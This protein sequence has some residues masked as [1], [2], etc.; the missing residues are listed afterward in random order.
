MREGQIVAEEQRHDLRWPRRTTS[1][2]FPSTIEITGRLEY[3]W[4]RVHYYSPRT[5]IDK[6]NH[7]CAKWQPV[8]LSE[9]AA[10][11]EHFMD[12]CRLLGQPAD[13][14][15]TAAFKARKQGRSSRSQMP[16]HEAAT[17]VKLIQDRCPN[18]LKLGFALW[19]RRPIQELVGERFDRHLSLSTAGRCLKHWGFT[20]QKPLRRAYEQDP[21]AVQHWLEVEYPKIRRRAKRENA[22]IHWEDEMGLRS[23]H[24]AGT[25][26][27]RKGQTPV[28]PGTGKRFSC[29]LISTITT[30]PRFV[31]Y[32]LP[33]GSPHCCLSR[34]SS[35]FCEASIKRC[36]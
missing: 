14:A 34:F 12:L 17:T 32:S 13:S 7:V 4:K 8:Q 25:S 18:Q 31:P 1:T 21:A 11:Q 29:H 20:P 5:P 3:T 19:T 22:E 9:R 33:S 35:G 36:C 27:G 15:T 24:Q 10:S 26:Y 6:V 23:D 16:G 28:I 2:L 30:G